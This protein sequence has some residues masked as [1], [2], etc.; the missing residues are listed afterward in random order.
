MTANGIPVTT[1]QTFDPTIF[2]GTSF[3]LHDV[4][5]THLDTIGNFTQVKSI[6]P[7][8]LHQ[9]AAPVGDVANLAKLWSAAKLQGR[10]VADSEDMTTHKM[11]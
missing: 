9:R 10:A 7:V 4:N 5:D 6:S 1:R 8:R 11:T 2:A 3:H